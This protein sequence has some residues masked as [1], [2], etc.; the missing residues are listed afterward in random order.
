MST[1]AAAESEEYGRELGR[2]RQAQTL[3]EEAGEFRA[4]LV[5]QGVAEEVAKVVIGLLDADEAARPEDGRGFLKAYFDTKALDPFLAAPP[6]VD[7]D[8]LLDENE[9]LRA[10]HEQ[11]SAELLELGGMWRGLQL[12]RWEPCLRA[13][14]EA[15][16]GGAEAGSHDAHALLA[17]AQDAALA[18]AAAA[19]L[20]APPGLARPPRTEGVPTPE[21]L[22]C[23]PQTLREWALEE[24]DSR[25]G[26][27][28]WAPG[29]I[30]VFMRALLPAFFAEAGGDGG[31]TA[32]Q[33][34]PPSAAVLAAE[35]EGAAVRAARLARRAAEAEAP[36]AEAE[37]APGGEEQGGAS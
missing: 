12:D 5:R 13:L 30:E 2:V 31:G 21:R 33:E 36:R 19:G 4:Y 34:Q 22:A 7:V 1:L 23:S 11:L 20:P 32:P 6:R 9:R 16:G 14:A 25:A 37:T 28:A 18:A 26:Q 35:A 3:S 15:H 10:E 8:Q 27:P 17:A 24:F 29:S